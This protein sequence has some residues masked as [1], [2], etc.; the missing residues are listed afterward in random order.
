MAPRKRAMS[1]ARRKSTPKVRAWL[2]GGPSMRWTPSR[3]AHSRSARSSASSTRLRS[4]PTSSRSNAGVDGARA[5]ECR[6]RICRRRVRST[7]HSSAIGGCGKRDQEPDFDLV[8]T[9]RRRSPAGGRHRCR[10]RPHSGPGG[11]HQQS[12]HEQRS[13][14]ARAAGGLSEVNTAIA[15]MDETTQ[16]NAAMV[17]ETTASARSLAAEARQLNEL[18]SG[19]NLRRGDRTAGAPPRSKRQTCKTVSRRARPSDRCTRRASSGAQARSRVEAQT[20][21]GR[22]FNSLG[23]RRPLIQKRKR[24]RAGACT[25]PF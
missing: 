25:R 19:F 2:C 4:R 9:G 21:A 8:C 18:V 17:Q 10:A 12:C 1:S 6:A 5:G 7:C 13:R 14:R 15:R 22:S 11:R 20:R 16:Q 23:R 3:R 24:R